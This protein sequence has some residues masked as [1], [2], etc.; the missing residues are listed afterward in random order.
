MSNGIV[1][2]E[3]NV[4]GIRIHVYAR[5]GVLPSPGDAPVTSADS[6][7]SVLFALH[8]RLSSSS[9]ERIVATAVESLEYVTAQE[10]ESGERGRE[11]I[12]VTFVRIVKCVE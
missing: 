1:P 12:V 10:K 5:A 9:D 4:G 3:F 2:K 8:G 11:L 6:S 7:V